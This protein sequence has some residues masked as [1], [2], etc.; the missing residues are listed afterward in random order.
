[1]IPSVRPTAALA[2]VALAAAKTGC[3]S[4]S[5]LEEL[6][7]E[8]EEAEALWL[9][10]RPVEYEALQVRLCECTPAMAGSVQLQVARSPVSH[11]AGTE[12]IVGGT[13]TQGGEPVPEQFL[14][15]FRTA[16]ELFDLIR[17]AV[18][19]GAFSLEATFDPDLGYPRS[20]AVDWHEQIADEESIYQME[21]ID[22]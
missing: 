9:E 1:M 5:E 3:S 17:E 12:V 14:Q 2:V 16:Q 22:P 15:H 13:Y 21:I 20:V 7:I 10:T 19:E 8:S 6:L 18:E 11:G 4:P